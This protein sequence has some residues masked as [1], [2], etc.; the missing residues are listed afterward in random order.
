MR[1]VTLVGGAKG[2]EKL[3]S[4]DD[5]KYQLIYSFEGPPLPIDGYI[6]TIQLL[7]THLEGH[8]QVI[9]SSSFKCESRVEETMINVLKNDIY[10]AGI[11]ALKMSKQQTK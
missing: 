3:V 8:T 2:R 6:S 7:P 5:E 11:K 10:I 1:N 9:W 4:R